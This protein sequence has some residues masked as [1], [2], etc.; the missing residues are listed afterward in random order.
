MNGT[1][2]GIRIPDTAL[3]RAATQ[4]I[5]NVHSELLYLHAMRSFTFGA[6]AGEREGLSF[7]A[8]L[9]YVSAMFHNVGLGAKHHRSPRRFEV[10]SANE[11][12]DFLRRQAVRESDIAL[13][14]TAIALHITPGI[15]AF[16]D[17]VAALLSAGV[18]MDVTGAE[19]KAFPERQREAVV[20]ALPREPGFKKLII[21][22]YARGTEQRPETTFGTV[23]SDVLDR[24]APEYLRVN[25]CGLILGSEWPN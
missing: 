23:C 22:A 20:E 5:R 17:P 12:S 3:T 15:P 1:V 13:V 18:R 19:F 9:L 16:L 14:W 2:A 24:W 7:D 6:L 4:H 25:F 11:A 8:E 10:D 21:E